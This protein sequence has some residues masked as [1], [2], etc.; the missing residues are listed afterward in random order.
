MLPIYLQPHEDGPLFYPTVST[1]SLGSHTLLDFYYHLEHAYDETD[2]KENSDKLLKD[3]LFASVLLE[4]RSLI[5]VCD[6]MYKVHLHGI[7]DRSCDVITD[8][9]VNLH[10]TSAQLGDELKR[11]T[12][13]SLTI[14]N[15]PKVLKAKFFFNKK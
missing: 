14:R 11:D 3:R 1:I 15:V 13:V 6:D 12:R 10:Y 2:T 4:P 7:E 8:K 9:V 5:L